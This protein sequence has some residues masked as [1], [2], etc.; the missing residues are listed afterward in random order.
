MPRVADPELPPPMPLWK[1]WLSAGL[2]LFALLLAL[3]SGQ[4]PRPWQQAAV[5]LLALGLALIMGA[6]T[7]P[8][9]LRRSILRRFLGWRGQARFTKAALLFLIGLLLV[10]LAA[11]NTGNNLLYLVGAAMLATLAVSGMA[12][13]LDLSGMALRFQLPLQ[14]S[15]EQDIPIQLTLENEKWL[16]PSYSLRILGEGQPVSATLATRKRGRKGHS[17]RRPGERVEMRPVYCALVRAHQSVTAVSSIRFPKRGQYRVTSFALQTSFPFA[18]TIKTRRFQYAK[19]DHLVLVYP[20]PLEAPALLNRFA[21]ASGQESLPQR[22]MGSDL[23]QVR[24]HQAGDSARAVHWKATAR[25]GE[26]RVREFTREQDRRLRIAFCLPPNTPGTEKA[27]SATAWLVQQFAQ[28]ELWIQ[29]TGYNGAAG[30]PAPFRLDWAP[31][32]QLSEAILEYLALV[33]TEA[34]PPMVSVAEADLYILSHAGQLQRPEGSHA[35]YAVQ[36]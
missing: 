9:L 10:L 1:G 30:R 6:L 27:I 25:T 35:L 31:A 20:A 26:L 8:N 28:Q 29:F 5:A 34:M 13:A 7:L 22:G 3:L 32:R 14:V 2:L 18:L 24:Q 23:Y 16:L 21:P 12:S 15:A 17:F 36:L 4:M 33:D 19:D 11:V